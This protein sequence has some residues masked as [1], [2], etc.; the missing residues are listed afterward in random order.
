MSLNGSYMFYVGN[1]VSPGF[2]KFIFS[3]DTYIW[4]EYNLTYK[5]A[6]LVRERERE[7]VCVGVCVF[8]VCVC[9]C[10]RVKISK[11][12]RLEKGSVYRQ[13]EPRV[14]VSSQW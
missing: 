13:A 9:V 3:Y 1:R 12:W 2:L 7:N 14:F 11:K 8:Y 10:V 5:V 4:N 6:F